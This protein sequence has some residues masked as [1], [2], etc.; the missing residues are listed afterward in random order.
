V[1]DA[2]TVSPPDDDPAARESRLHEALLQ[3]LMR[4][5]SLC[6]VR[7]A[8][9]ERE[10]AVWHV[11]HEGA[12]Y[13]VSGGSEQPLPGVESAEEAVVVV[14]TKDTRQRMLAW[15]AEV[16][17]VAPDSAEYDAV[18]GELLGAR[19][20]LPDLPEARDRW[21]RECRVTRL[22]PTG[23]LEEHPG[24]LPDGE[25]AAAPAPTPATTRRGLPRVL[26]RRQTRRPDLR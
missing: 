21:R 10:R 11:W 23:A 3:E 14:R 20:N 7:L 5:S 12:A 25:L 24:G 15:R 1:W 22:R 17:G 9:A 8:G 16:G 2:R 26:H 18:V 19:L 6:W 4:K 13:V